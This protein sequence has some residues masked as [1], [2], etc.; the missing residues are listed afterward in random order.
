ML[1]LIRLTAP[2]PHAHKPRMT[3]LAID[4]VLR[5]HNRAAML[6]GA[7]ESLFAADRSG[8]TLRLLL[9]DNASGDETPAV[10]QRL[11]AR[12]GSRLV[13]LHES[14]PGGQHALNCAIARAEAPVIAFF[15]DDE[16]VPPQWLQVIAREFADPATVFV[17]GPYRPQWDGD[18]PAWLPEGYGGVLGIIDYGDR[19]LRYFHDFG[20][21][22][23]QGNCALRRWVFDQTG[24]YPP[25]LATAEDR[26][27]NSWLEQRD[28]VGYYCPDM[29]ITHLMQ[30]ER[31]N[32]AYFERW[33][34][35]EGHDR[36]VA[37]RM[38]GLASLFRQRW[39]W[40]RL[41]RAAIT[42]LLGH[43]SESERFRARLDLI[44]ARANACKRIRLAVSS[45]R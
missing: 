16:R 34:V 20:G 11:A 21:M 31:L 6:E 33:A 38:A 23:T 22:L 7:V 19:R 10:I 41:V 14:R 36:A 39:Y 12:H 5:T 42:V 29:A 1:A 32:R 30:E 15:D 37:D 35:R 9:V 18:V 27:L 25:E 28:A 26:W 13:P 24:P 17:A 2:P 4:V 40:G 43:G 44:Q 3:A 45:R 8:I